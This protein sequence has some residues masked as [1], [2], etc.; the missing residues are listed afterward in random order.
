MRTNIG[1]ARQRGPT[2]KGIMPFD[3]TKP[4]NGAVVTSPELRSQFNA[5]KAISDGLQ[6][7]LNQVQAQLASLQTQV[8]NIP[9]GP[10]GPQGDPGPQGPPFADAVVDGVTTL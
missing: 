5:L 2:M 8:A 7:A 1:A 3:S 10:Q 6:A 4:A 9:A